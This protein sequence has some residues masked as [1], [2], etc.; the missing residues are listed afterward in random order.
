MASVLGGIVKS[1]AS[2]LT[3]VKFWLALIIL[4]VIIFFGLLISNIALTGME[5]PEAFPIVAG[6][7]IWM[8]QILILFA[9]L[10]FLLYLACNVIK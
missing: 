4:A 6:I 2:L 3:K 10:A 8:I 5:H 7:G 1:L 9:V